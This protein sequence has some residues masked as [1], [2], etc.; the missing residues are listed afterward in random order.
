MRQVSNCIFVVCLFLSAP[1][2]AQS[3]HARQEAEQPDSLHAAAP[4]A[5]SN[6]CIY[7]DAQFGIGAGRCISDQ[8][9]LVCQAP[10][11][12]HPAAWWNSGRQPLCK[13]RVNT[14]PSE[15]TAKKPPRQVK[16]PVKPPVDTTRR[17]A[18]CPLQSPPAVAKT[19]P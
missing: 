16:P 10:D 14:S 18:C 2:D 11:A 13:G 8:L 1:A 7:E 6:V 5:I 3:P 17:K 9:W 19:A 4:P 15:V 12:D